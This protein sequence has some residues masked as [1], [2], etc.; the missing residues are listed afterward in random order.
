MSRYRA[1]SAR[2]SSGVL[3]SS[4]RASQPASPTS[5]SRATRAA[6]PIREVVTAVFISRYCLAPKNRDTITEQPMLHP[7]AKAM[8]IRVIS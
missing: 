6:Q 3:M 2:I 7:K 4:S 5:I 1:E 8:K